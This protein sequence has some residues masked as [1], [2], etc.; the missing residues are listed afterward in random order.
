MSPSPR[1]AS[2][3]TLHSVY[4]QGDLRI[5]VGN[6]LSIGSGLPTWEVLNRGLLQALIE[7]DADDLNLW[8]SLLSPAVP[9]V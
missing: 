3:R 4:R 8:T 5:L 7:A 9:A 1:E 2:V 6:G